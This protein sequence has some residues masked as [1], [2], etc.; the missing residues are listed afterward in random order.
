MTDITERLRIAWQG[1]GD[2]ANAER[3]EAAAEIDKLRDWVRKLDYECS[4]LRQRNSDLR[5]R[6]T[7]LLS[8]IQELEAREQ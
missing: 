2:M 1:M 3:A 7:R 8:T 6:N 5:E 4:N